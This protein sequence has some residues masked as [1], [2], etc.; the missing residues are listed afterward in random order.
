MLIQASQI[1]RMSKLEFSFKVPDCRQMTFG[2]ITRDDDAVSEPN[3]SSPLSPDSLS[4]D[5]VLITEM[6]ELFERA[7]SICLLDYMSDVI[8]A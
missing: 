7:V 4:V 5:Y 8:C 2:G 1:S 6:S 3:T